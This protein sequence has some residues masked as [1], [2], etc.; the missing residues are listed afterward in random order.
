MKCQICGFEM[1]EVDVSYDMDYSMTGYVCPIDHTGRLSPEQE[2]NLY[3]NT[4]AD[5]SYDAK[6]GMWAN[7]EW[8]LKAFGYTEIKPAEH[9]GFEATK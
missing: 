2:R 1:T 8:V 4:D 9:G 3:E 6:Y 7:H 5:W